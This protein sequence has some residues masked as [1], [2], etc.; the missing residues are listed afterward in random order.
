ML[1]ETRESHFIGHVVQLRD[2]A[3]KPPETANRATV[4]PD[5]ILAA[6]AQPQRPVNLIEKL[7]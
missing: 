6:A 7:L 3:E 1:Q 4:K 5:S 2:A